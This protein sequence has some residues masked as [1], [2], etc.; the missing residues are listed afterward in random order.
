METADK[1]GYPVI[2]KASA[3]GGGRGMRVV[4]RPEELPSLLTQA[5]QE[6][7]ATFSNADVYLEKYIEGFEKA[8]ACFTR[9]VEIDPNYGEAYCEL[10]K[11]HFLFTMNLFYTPAYGFERAKFYAKKALSLNK[12]LGAAHYLLGQI[13]F[14]YECDFKRSKAEYELAEHCND[15]FYFTGV[16]IDRQIEVVK[17]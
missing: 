7:G 16:V 9:A 1:I 5:Q 15:S 13:N 17:E 10:A 12:E 6:A 3:G 14:W 8:L 2:L 4:N 11:V